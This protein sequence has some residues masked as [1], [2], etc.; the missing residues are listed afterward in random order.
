MTI[1]NLFVFLTLLNTLCGRDAHPGV[2]RIGP[3][4]S[5]ICQGRVLRQ[6]QRPGRLGPRHVTTHAEAAGAVARGS[7]RR[8]EVGRS[9][10]IGF[11]SDRCVSV[12]DIGFGAA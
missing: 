3:G 12:P 8:A 10:C 6:A 9:L 11:R 2:A 5:L 7:P 4:R 1:E